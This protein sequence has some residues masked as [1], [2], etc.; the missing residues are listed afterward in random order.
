MQ[1]INLTSLV[2]GDA[3]QAGLQLNSFPQSPDLPQMLVPA[4]DQGDGTG[5]FLSQV[6][7]GWFLTMLVAVSNV[8][9]KQACQFMLIDV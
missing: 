4:L 9:Q 5:F 8:F 2:Y 7:L 1:N 3:E 6:C